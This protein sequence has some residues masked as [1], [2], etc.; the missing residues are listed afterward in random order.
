MICEVHNVQ[1]GCFFMLQVKHA[2]A[3]RR[4]L[5][6]VWHVCVL[7]NAAKGLLPPDERLNLDTRLPLWIASLD[8]QSQ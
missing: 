6:K 7:P 3:G 5:N 4:V 1:L 8:S 2:A